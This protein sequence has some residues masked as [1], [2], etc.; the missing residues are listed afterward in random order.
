MLWL[1]DSGW[2]DSWCHFFV[3]ANEHTDE[4]TLIK[5]QRLVESLQ[6]SRLGL[7]M[8]S[9]QLLWR[10]AFPWRRFT[11]WAAAPFVTL[12][13]SVAA[14]A[15]VCGASLRPFGI[16]KKEIIQSP[17]FLDMRRQDRAD[18]NAP[19]IWHGKYKGCTERFE[20]NQLQGKDWNR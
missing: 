20:E 8:R 13:L 7:G 17:C 16:R 6:Q 12:C 2:V 10:K 3:K 5:S 15:Y 11:W 18:A 19:L 4:E 14:S 1:L 9:G